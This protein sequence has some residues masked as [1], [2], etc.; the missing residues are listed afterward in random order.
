MTRKIWLEYAHLLVR[1]L[2]YCARQNTSASPN[3]PVE[4]IRTVPGS[5]NTFGGSCARLTIR[6]SG[7]VPEQLPLINELDCMPGGCIHSGK[8]RPFA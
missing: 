4:A 1:E 3:V 5:Q 6:P 8:R 7:D 2:T